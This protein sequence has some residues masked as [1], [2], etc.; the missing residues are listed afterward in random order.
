MSKIVNF[1]AGEEVYK[2]YDDPDGIYILQKGSMRLRYTDSVNEVDL[3]I[4]KEGEFF[5][6]WEVL[7]GIFRT[8]TVIAEQES[9]CIKMSVS[10]FETMILSKQ[11]LFEQILK[12]FCQLIKNKER[13]YFSLGA[14]KLN[15][16]DA[17]GIA[18][19]FLTIRNPTATFEV[20]NKYMEMCPEF[21]NESG[22]V[23]LRN[24]AETL[25]NAKIPDAKDPLEQFLE[26]NNFYGPKHKMDVFNVSA[27]KNFL[28]I[29][30]SG[31]VICAE[32]EKNDKFYYIE[33]GQVVCCRYQKDVIRYTKVCSPGEFIGAY[34][35]IM[36]VPYNETYIAKGLVKVLEFNKSNFKA[37]FDANTQMRLM[38][39]RQLANTI[40]YLDFFN[41]LERK[42]VPVREKLAII[43][44]V[45]AKRTAGERINE[46]FLTPAE[47]NRINS[48]SAQISLDSE[49]FA[50]WI[51]CSIA[52]VEDRLAYL[53]D[54]R[55]IKRCSH[56]VI[57]IFDKIVSL[58]Q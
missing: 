14:R 45:Q 23:S 47:V 54:M 58:I 17:Y 13:K 16:E 7:T 48:N 18:A 39:L 56:N 9:V 40:F 41:T 3:N 27:F 51:G 12:S 15:Y 32:M 52:E 43:L 29:Y 31:E 50:N 38:L 30:D 49:L 55:A 2:Q 57:I 21:K 42:D 10:E 1:F 8:N 20:I 36:D 6:I 22:L 53:S 5:G 26:M 44:S 35:C 28:S 46:N 25:C 24:K 19:G 33:S 37:I 34:S 11:N 4:I